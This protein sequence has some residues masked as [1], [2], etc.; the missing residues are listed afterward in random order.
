MFVVYKKFC[1]CYCLRT[2]QC[3]S[4]SLPLS[5]VIQNDPV[6]KK[7]FIV[8]GLYAAGEAACASGEGGRE[9]GRVEVGRELGGGRR[10]LGGGREGARR[11]EEGARRR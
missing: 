7:D 4:L 10:E 2:W 6:T 11:R 3:L 9:G 5:Q 1:C 8:P